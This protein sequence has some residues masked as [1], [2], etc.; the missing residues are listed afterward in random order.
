MRGALGRRGRVERG[1]GVSPLPF[2]FWGSFPSVPTTAPAKRPLLS[3]GLSRF[4]SYCGTISSPCPGP[5]GAS[6]PHGHGPGV[7]HQPHLLP[8]P[9]QTPG[10]S[11]AH[12]SGWETRP[13][14][15]KEPSIHSWR[16]LRPQPWK[17]APP[18]LLEGAPPTPWRK[19]R[20]HPW[21]ESPAHTLERSPAHTPGRDQLSHVA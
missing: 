6:A 11:L 13:H 19:P 2:L 5:R 21:E 1:W 18:T 4:S 10:G 9:A 14:P 17:I 20:P 12:T 16:E 15:W 8:G 3:L 7:L